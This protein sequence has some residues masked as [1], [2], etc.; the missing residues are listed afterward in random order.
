MF[1]WNH[2]LDEIPLDELSLLP[3]FNDSKSLPNPAQS[4]GGEIYYLVCFF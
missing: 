3:L 4:W 1:P 2:V